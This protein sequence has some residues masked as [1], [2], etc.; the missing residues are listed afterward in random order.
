[1]GMTRRETKADRQANE[2][3]WDG[4]TIPV[5]QMTDRMTGR[6]IVVSVVVALVG[7]SVLMTLLALGYT[8]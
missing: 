3:K 7:A 4:E 2:E 1:M 5:R 6:Q 8:E